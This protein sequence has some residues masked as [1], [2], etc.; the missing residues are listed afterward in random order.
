MALTLGEH[1]YFASGQYNALS[2]DGLMLL[3]HELAHVVQQRAGRIV[4]PWGRG[5]ALVQDPR[6]ESEARD[7]ALRLVR[8]TDPMSG[9][10]GRVRSGPG[11]AAPPGTGGPP[12]ETAVPALSQVLDV[13]Q[14]ST[15]TGRLERRRMTTTNRLLARADQRSEAFQATAVIYHNGQRI[16]SFPFVDER[17][18]SPT[19]KYVHVYA[20]EEDYDDETHTIET[21]ETWTSRDG[22]MFLLEQIVPYLQR[23]L[24]DLAASRETIDRD[25]GRVKSGSAPSTTMFG[26]GA[27]YPPLRDFDDNMHVIQVEFIGP[28]GT[29]MHCQAALKQ[30]R[31][32]LI[33]TY[34]RTRTG[35]PIVIDII[36]RYTEEQGKKYVPRFNKRYG[37]KYA[38]K[39]GRFDPQRR[40]RAVPHWELRL[41]KR[42]ESLK[43]RQQENISRMRER[44]RISRQK[45]FSEYRSRHWVKK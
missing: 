32:D 26:G 3:G 19:H 1:I 37:S 8:A 20:E 36:T 28:K 29:C 16:K 7:L 9:K 25:S 27:P 21:D 30:Y 18:D 24:Q 14:P 12:R 42:P 40:R 35:T 41:G 15:H 31:G 5:V 38:R 34:P 44:Q 33:G 23:Y 2:P 45:K 22:E 39:V 10:R 13:A 43:D 4:N 6:L 11:E 17:G